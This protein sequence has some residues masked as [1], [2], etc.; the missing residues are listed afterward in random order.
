MY[1]KGNARAI[2]FDGK[3]ASSFHGWKSALVTEVSGLGLTA[4]EWL[5]LLYLRTSGTAFS[6]VK[7]AREMG[8]EDPR[9]ALTFVWNEFK[10]R[11]KRHPPAAKKVLYE[12]QNFRTVKEND[13]NTLWEFS[14]V[15]RQA[16][17]H[18]AMLS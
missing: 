8:I 10:E 17:M 13:Y 11:Y 3:D 16:V 2:K 18:S 15:C 7:R 14:L 12:L 5:E 9:T 6:V 4:G 1:F